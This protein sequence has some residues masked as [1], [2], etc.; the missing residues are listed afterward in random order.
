MTTQLENNIRHHHAHLKPAKELSHLS[1][2]PSPLCM[3]TAQLL[4]RKANGRLHGNKN[5]QGKTKS[6]P[7]PPDS[8][9]RK[10]GVFIIFLFFTLTVNNESL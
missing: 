7:A 3:N 4:T 8:W 5:T 1:S 6:N 10:V 9:K 2:P